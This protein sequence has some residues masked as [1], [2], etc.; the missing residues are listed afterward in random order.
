RLSRALTREAAT[1]FFPASP[2][3]R[4]SAHARHAGKRKRTRRL[5][6]CFIVH[7]ASVTSTGTAD[8]MSSRAPGPAP[9]PRARLQTAR[10]PCRYAAGGDCVAA[11]GGGGSAGPYRPRLSRD[12]EIWGPN[13]GY[14]AAIALRAAGVATALRRPAS[15][16]GHFLGVA[17]F[18]A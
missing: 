18:D 3:A 4:R 11:G 10:R 13:G 8:R 16:A 9:R 7:H 6:E 12:W 5:H 14:V 1:F 15:L 2:R 17:D